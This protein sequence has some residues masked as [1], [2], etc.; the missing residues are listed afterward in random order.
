M[1]NIL[2]VIGSDGRAVFNNTIVQLM[3]SF[4]VPQGV[5]AAWNESVDHVIGGIDV[6]VPSEAAEPEDSDTGISN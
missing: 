5:K 3:E 2:G 1:R 6:P 4:R